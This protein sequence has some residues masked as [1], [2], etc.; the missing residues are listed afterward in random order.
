MQIE[1]IFNDV[2][3]SLKYFANMPFPDDGS[4]FDFENRL[5]SEEL[6][7]NA[8]DIKQQHDELFKN[9]NTEQLN[10]YNSVVSCVNNRR[11]GVF[12]VYG[13]GGCEKTFLWKTLCCA[14]RSPGKIVLPVAFSDITAVLLPGGRTT[15]SRFHI[16][17]NLDHYSST[18]ISN[19]SDLLN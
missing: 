7:Y 4:I 18:D 9:L 10:V 8:S 2:G 13:S 1:K 15:H 17:L 5:L 6:G 3:K 12:F 16:P 14:L 11:G 19:G